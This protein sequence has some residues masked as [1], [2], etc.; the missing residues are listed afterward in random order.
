[1]ANY[2]ATLYVDGKINF[3]NSLQEVEDSFEADVISYGGTV[4]S[5]TDL[6]GRLMI[7]LTLPDTKTGAEL[8]TLIELIKTNLAGEWTVSG[9]AKFELER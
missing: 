4:N 8:I 7:K 2:D 5:T 6:G 9:K 1:M 3:A